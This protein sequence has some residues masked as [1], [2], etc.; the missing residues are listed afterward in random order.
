[1]KMGIIVNNLYSEQAEYTT[2]L[3]AMEAVNRGHEVWYIN[4]DGF[5]LRPD[6]HTYAHACV[7]PPHRHR[8]VRKFLGDVQAAVEQNTREIDLHELDVLLPRNDPS[9]DALSRPWAWMAAINFGRLVTRAG[10][11]V[12]NDPEGLA[13]GLTKLYMEYFPQQIRPRTLVTRSKGEA[14]DFIAEQGG[15][16][17][18][19]P[20]SGS[21]GRNVFLI[22]PHDTP[23]INQMIEAVSREGYFIVQEYLPDAIH[24]DTRLFMMNGEPLRCQGRIAA[25][26]RQRR[27]GD[28]DMRSN[29]T[30]GAIA[31]PAQVTTE[32]LQ[33]AELTGARLKQDGIFFAGLDIVGD[34]IMEINIQTPGGLD[35]AEALE[36]VPFRH[37]I[38][39]AIERKVA[40]W[41]ARPGE[42]SNA[43]LAVWQ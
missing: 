23:N 19:K 26:H 22:R 39:E 38:V 28:A 25:I 41:R 31:R 2:T 16:T 14:K 18:L 29:I 13:L 37:K 30:A 1:M 12:L 3:I 10:I 33:L 27:T 43:E 36:G 9:L 21:G 11:P 17:V 40:H 42:L 4:V 5:A 7:V 8:S 32:M 6:D 20:L 15:F 35:N 34:K 24:G